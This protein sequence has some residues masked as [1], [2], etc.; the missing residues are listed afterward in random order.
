MIE[1]FKYLKGYVRVKVWGF[2]PERFMNLCSNKN[3]LLWNIVKEGDIYI[4]N[5]SLSGFYQ[6]KPIVRKTSTKVVILERHGL[7]FFVP[8]ILSRKIFVLGLTLCITFWIW[9]SNYVWDID[10]SGNY[11][12][13]EDVFMTFLSENNID[14][15]TKKSD[16]DLK[17]LEK[18]IRQTFTEITWTSAKINGTKLEIAVKENDALV[19]TPASNEEEGGKDLIAEY[20]GIIT[21]MIVR[22]GV[23]MVSIGD[24]VESGTVLVEGRVP[25]YN[26]DTTVREYQYVASDADIYME[27]VLDYEDILAYDY[28]QKEYTGREK[29]RYFLRAFDNELKMSAEAP[30]LVY[31]CII[32]ENKPALFDKLSIP[33]F[34]GSYTYRE[35]QN[36]EYVYTL[37]EAKLIM[38]EKIKKYMEGLSEKGVQIIEKDVKIENGDHEWIVSGHFYVIE[39][40][41]KSVDT[42]VDADPIDTAGE[43]IP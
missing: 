41:G 4:M 16:L 20:D 10:L 43:E 37:S 36:V 2:S 18:A 31:D 29:T 26:E 14:I 38:E 1:L 40:I 25:I 12:I 13:T 23:P 15:G 39:Q 42:P 30:Y 28:I 8:V 19:I 3:I 24:T 17:E 33:V 22:S 9:S 35:Y 6:L 11:Q 5:I 32:K 21:S 34:W 7:P 27:H